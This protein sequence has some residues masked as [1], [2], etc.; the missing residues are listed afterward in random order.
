MLRAVRESPKYTGSIS[1]HQHPG[2][3][4]QLVGLPLWLESA[5]HALE[6]R[7]TMEMIVRQPAQLFVVHRHRALHSVYQQLVDQGL[8]P[9]ETW[10]SHHA[11]QLGCWSDDP[12]SRDKITAAWLD[13]ITERGA[14]GLSLEMDGTA[15]GLIATTISELHQLFVR[16]QTIH[17]VESL[18]EAVVKLW[19]PDVHQQITA[20]IEDVDTAHRQRLRRETAPNLL[21]PMLQADIELLERQSKGEAVERR[22]ATGYPK[23]DEVTGGFGDGNVIVVAA[24]PGMGKTSFALD[25]ALHLALIG[26]A[27]CFFSFE[28]AA[29][30]LLRR[31]I[32]KMT[33]IPVLKLRHGDLQEFQVDMI[34]EAQPQLADL[35]LFF[36]ERNETPQGIEQRVREINRLIHPGRIG[37]VVVDHLQLM[38][39]RDTRRYERRDL[40][41]GAYS[42]QLKT[43]AKELQLCVI[44]LSQL[45]R[46]VESRPLDQRAPRLGDLRESGA[47]EQDSDIVIGLHRRFVDT[48]NIADQSHAELVILKNRSGPCGRIN[49]KWLGNL[50]TFR[51]ADDQGGSD[52][53][54]DLA[55]I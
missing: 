16:R 14:C 33:R 28:M 7:K 9:T 8:L 5:G 52:N 6:A 4:G 32:S 19:T 15:R 49:L 37:L 26:I 22:I 30:E 39:S 20:L 38:G 48:Q 11:Q 13:E 27:V 10:I 47:I 18:H 31:V 25:V 46:Q 54:P 43:L 34:R 17:A 50:A 29:K 12:G 24:R 51:P 21:G 23:L 35:P 3:E 40:Q 45:N 1:Q 41:L 53:A 2:L 42:G 36:E 55:N 44:A